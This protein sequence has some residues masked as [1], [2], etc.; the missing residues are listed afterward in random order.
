MSSKFRPFLEALSEYRRG[1]NKPPRYLNSSG[2]AKVSKLQGSRPAKVCRFCAGSCPG[3]RTSW[4][5]EECVRDYKI[6]C[7]DPAAVSAA[8]VERDREVCGSCGLDTRLFLQDMLNLPLDRIEKNLW[9]L[10]GFVSDSKL[11]A[12]VPTLGG[13]KMLLEEITRARLWQAHHVVPVSKGGG[14][15]PLDGFLTLCLRCHKAYH[16]KVFQYT[17]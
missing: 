3:R 17:R 16:S 12:F 14:L 11:E 10:E 2:V 6:A 5:S 13:T 1:L 7:N 15:C 4:C 8:L 9:R